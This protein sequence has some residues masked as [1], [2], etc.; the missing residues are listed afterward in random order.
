VSTYY[1][2]IFSTMKNMRTTAPL[3]ITLPPEML[4]RA[5]KLAAREN[6]TM[7]E[8][9]REALRR[10]EQGAQA[11][12]VRQQALIEFQRAVEAFRVT[13]RRDG[14]DK[15]SMSDLNREIS[16]AREER[17]KRLAVARSTK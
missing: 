17:R 7:S 9:V 2:V 11:P 8:L 1:L 6:R 4:K 12:E 15:L 16:A 5:K 14:L 13:A 3:S 10:Y